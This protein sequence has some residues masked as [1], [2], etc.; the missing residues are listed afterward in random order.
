[1]KPAPAMEM[2]LFQII[3]LF[4]HKQRIKFSFKLPDRQI[5]LLNVP[6]GSMPLRSPSKPPR[7]ELNADGTEEPTDSIH[8]DNEG[9]YHGDGLW[10][11]RLV[12]SL[13]PAAVDEALN[14]LHMGSN[15][16]FELLK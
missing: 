5:M 8:G 13:T 3:V 6:K 9:P 12:V 10:R 4:L 11:W 7:E 15:M 1:M 16:G 2:K 14:I